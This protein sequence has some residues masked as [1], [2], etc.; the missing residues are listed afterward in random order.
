MFEDEMKTLQSRFLFIG[1]LHMTSSKKH[2]YANNDQFASN[3][4]IACKTMQCVSVPSLKL[5]GQIKTELS[6]K[7]VGEVSVLLHG[8]IGWRPSVAY[9]HGCRNVNIWRFSQL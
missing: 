9:Q 2:D 8:K 3:F 7:E 6:A 1:G 4:D 5:F